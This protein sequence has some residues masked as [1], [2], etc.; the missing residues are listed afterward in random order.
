M[1]T[2]AKLHS[3]ERAP[4]DWIIESIGEAI[5]QSLQAI[6]HE[7][8]PDRMALLLLRLA[9]AEVI[10]PGNEPETEL[11]KARRLVAKAELIVARHRQRIAELQT[12]HRPTEDALN[13]LDTFIETLAAMKYQQRL[14]R[15]EAEGRDRNPGWFFWLVHET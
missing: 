14:L 11:D 6:I 3:I 4:D 12:E 7:P 8:I 10:N 9:L 13:V 15:H 5:R 2:V 1:T